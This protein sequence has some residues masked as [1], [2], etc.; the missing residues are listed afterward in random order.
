MKKWFSKVSITTFLALIVLLMTTF[1]IP[2]APAQAVTDGS[3][4]WG[5]FIGISGYQYLSLDWW[6]G[7]DDA[8]DFSQALSPTWGSSHINLL[9][10]SQATRSGS[11]SAIGWLAD[12]SSSDD[13]VLFFFAGDGSEE[14]LWPYDL[15]YVSD[16]ISGSQLN[17]AFSSVQA[18]KIVFIFSFWETDIFR[19]AISGSGRVM[20]FGA[21]S[22]EAIYWNVS[23][24]RNVFCSHLIDAFDNFDGNDADHSYELS[25]EEVYNYAAP[26]TTSEHSGQHPVLVD[27]YSGQLPLIA[28]F[29]FDNNVSLPP[30]A[31][32][33]TI[34]G[35]AYTTEPKTFYWAPGGSHTVTVPELVN[36][37]TGTRY[38]FTDWES[39][40]SAS[41]ITV[42][43]GH[44]TA[45][46]N[47]EYQ[48]TITS[49]FDTPT[50]E[51]WYVDG[52]T[53]TFTITG[54]LETSDTKR[55]FTGWSGDYTGTDESGTVVMNAPK[56]LI[57]NWRTEFLLVINSEYGTPTGAGWHDE[58]AS[59]P[60]AVEEIV[61]VIIRQI[62][63]GW[64]GDLTSTTASTSVTMDGPKT[65]TATWHTDYIYLYIVI[66]V[67]VVGIAVIVVTII[68]VR[69]KGKT[70][71]GPAEAPPVYTPP[72][73]GAGE[74]PPPPPP[75]AS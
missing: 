14:G 65:I 46:Y 5:V 60:I 25:A 35:A 45:D 8:Q 19:N 27:N 31:T 73:P 33:V 47:K 13:T 38:V 34:D 62:F 71:R 52:T 37:G 58:G 30:G 39:G 41:S 3:E 11:L 56:S 42:S 40:G 61:G 22:T 9:T 4:C 64:T 67:P 36:A 44:Y 49:P 70:P 12:H 17:S 10:G 74:P 63:D 26:L 20:M 51:G 16:L 55:F 57:A 53:A 21:H 6:N 24:Y 66:I 32:V 29:I 68:L 50:G 72:P 59:V 69:R 15:Y 1:A 23:S 7:D 2:C 18:Q 48:L 54:Y 75:P 28:K 43:H